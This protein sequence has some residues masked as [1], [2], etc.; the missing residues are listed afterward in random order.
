MVR[1]VGFHNM[2]KLTVGNR[3]KFTGNVRTFQPKK[4]GGGPNKVAA[5]TAKAK[6]NNFHP[7]GS[8]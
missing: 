1:E 6:I 5:P 4:K 2:V 3:G 8:L 7:N